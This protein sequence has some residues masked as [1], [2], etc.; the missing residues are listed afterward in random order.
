[1]EHI[2]KQSRL[3]LT[4]E[5]LEKRRQHDRDLYHA[6]KQNPE[7]LAKE[8]ERNRIR[9][10]KKRMDQDYRE[11]TRAQQRK[12]K[13]EKWANDQSMKE[14]VRKYRRDKYNSDPEYRARVLALN[15]K[16]SA[17]PKG[18]I[19]AALRWRGEV[20]QE[21]TL[22]PYEMAVILSRQHGRCLRCGNLFDDQYPPTKDHVI[23][24]SAGGRLTLL[25][26]QLLCKPCNSAKGA[27]HIDYR[28]NCPPSVIINVNDG[29]S[30]VYE[31]WNPKYEPRPIQVK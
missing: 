1:M 11:K 23:P 24:F 19:K 25:N 12:H 20:A 10:A 5:Q 21:D 6:N 3:N 2:K 17:S 16:Y 14:R 9:M 7:W 18:R 8:K 30:E 28:K 13:S 29:M 22:T 31:E 15:R 26:T 27:A 4:P